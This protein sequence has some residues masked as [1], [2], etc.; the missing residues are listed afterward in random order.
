MCLY[1][2]LF[3][4]RLPSV[5]LGFG[6]AIL[7]FYIARTLYSDDV[8]ILAAILFALSP[9]AI[10]YNKMV[11]MDNAAL[12]FTALS[13]YFFFKFYRGSGDK[14]LILSGVFVGTALISRYTT[15]LLVVFL[16]LFL[17]IKGFRKIVLFLIFASIVP[18]VFVLSMFLLRI[19]SYWFVQ[20]IGLRMI[21][22]VLPAL[23]R[24]REASLYFAWILPLFA[25][26]VP[27]M[28]F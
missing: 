27:S 15:A 7:T 26:S 23:L 8:A 11:L 10:Y 3:M 28:I 14:H 2:S 1:S 19:H 4:V 6:A 25:S 24:L 20:T 22:F 13:L 9:Y 18:S 5:L 16:V 17:V 12:F 21:R